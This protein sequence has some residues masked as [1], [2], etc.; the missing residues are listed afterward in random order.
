MNKIALTIVGTVAGVL[1]LAGCGSGGRAT[2]PTGSVSTGSTSIPSAPPWASHFSSPQVA[3]IQDAIRVIN[4]SR[5]AVAQLTVDDAAA[6]AVFSKYFVT[7]S[8]PEAQLRQSIAYRIKSTGTPLV[9]WTRPIGFGAFHGAKDKILTIDQCV[10][11]SM[12]KTTVGGKP[13]KYAY[14]SRRQEAEWVLYLTD[15]GWLIGASGSKSSC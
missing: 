1:A 15:R 9:V 11:N 6:R 14:N 5:H 12:V 4:A 2:L 8:V 7:P 3:Q 13:A 10:D